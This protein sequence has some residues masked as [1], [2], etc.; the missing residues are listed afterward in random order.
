MVRRGGRGSRAGD[1]CRA[2]GDADARRAGAAGQDQPGHREGDRRHRRPLSLQHGPRGHHGAEQRDHRG[3]RR[4]RAGTAWRRRAA[5]RRVLVEAVETT[6]APAGALRSA[7]GRRAVGD[8]GAR[9]HLGRALAR[10]RPSL[11]GRTT[12]SKSRCRS[13]ARCATGSWS[14][15]TRAGRRCWQR[16]RRSRASSGIWPAVTVVKEIVVP[17]KLVNLVVR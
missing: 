9:A 15:P 6:G 4:R 5:G 3:A 13:T 10:G 16:P 12:R 7:H 17:G 2:E 1:R 11:P 8:D 14:P